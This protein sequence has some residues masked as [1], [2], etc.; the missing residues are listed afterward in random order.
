VTSYLSPLD[1]SP[2]LIQ[3]RWYRNYFRAVAG[4]P[5][6]VG[7]RFGV[8]LHDTEG[9]NSPTAAENGALYNSRRDSQV[10]CQVLVDENSIVQSVLDIDVCFSAGTPWNDMMLHVEMCGFASETADQWRKVYR[11]ANTA[12]YLAKCAKNGILDPSMKFRYAEEWT[13]N[14]WE[15]GIITTHYEISR[16]TNIPGQWRDAIRKNKWSINNHTDPGPNYYPTYANR[17]QL[18]SSPLGETLELAK[19]FLNP[20]IPVTPYDGEEMYI[21]TNKEIYP[22]GSTNYNPG[23]V[24]W[25]LVGGKKRHIGGSEWYDILLPGGVKANVAATTGAIASLPDYGG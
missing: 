12:W 1:E 4:S 9:G 2:P 22:L 23:T 5:Y 6:S 24:F 15:T 13:Q 10:S 7:T 25:E 8:V 14:M 20:S 19:F 21:I 17:D 3:A 18:A 11:Q 16:A